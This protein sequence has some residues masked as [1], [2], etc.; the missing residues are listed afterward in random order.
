MDG[1]RNKKHTFDKLIVDSF[2][3][4][5]YDF[6][7]SF[8]FVLESLRKFLDPSVSIQHVEDTILFVSFN[9]GDVEV[10]EVMFT[11]WGNGFVSTSNLTLPDTQCVRNKTFRVIVDYRL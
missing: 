4:R 5:D 11:F 1:R 6:K 7:F 9:V 10:K 3:G 8:S 2:F